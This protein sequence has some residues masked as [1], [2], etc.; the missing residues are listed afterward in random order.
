MEPYDPAGIP[1]GWD[2]AQCTSDHPSLSGGTNTGFA[3]GWYGEDGS[4]SGACWLGN[5]Q[6]IDG[7]IHYPQLQTYEFAWEL[8]VNIPEDCAAC[9]H[10]QAEFTGDDAV[11]FSVN[12]QSAGGKYPAY[13]SLFQFPPNYGGFVAGNNVL[14]LNITNYDG[15]YGAWGALVKGS[16]S[17][18]CENIAQ[19][20]DVSYLECTDS[21]PPLQQMN[22]NQ[23]T[24]IK[25]LNLLTG[26]YMPKYSFPWAQSGYTIYNVNA[27][28]ASPRD[29]IMYAMIRYTEGS[30]D[31]FL[32]RIGAEDPVKIRFVARMGPSNAASFDQHGNLFYPSGWKL[33]KLSRPDLIM[34]EH[35]LP[36]NVPA[37]DPKDGTEEV[38]H[39]YIP[40]WVTGFPA[41][42]GAVHADLLQSGTKQEWLIGLGTLEAKL[43]LIRTDQP[44][45][46]LNNQ[47]NPDFYTVDADGYVTD[48][49]G[50]AF[51]YRD[52]NGDHH[53][54]FL[55]NSGGQKIF[56][57]DLATVTLSGSGIAGTGT[58]TL[59]R[60]G[61][62]NAV[63]AS[64]DG[65][66]C[67]LPLGGEVPIIPF[68]TCNDQDGVNVGLD[69]N[70]ITDT[71]C[72]PGV[73]ANPDSSYR[74][75]PPAFSYASG[76]SCI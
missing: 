58:A 75:V 9:A 8:N 25:E 33:W 24:S 47:I 48:T 16:I 22:G 15:N 55:G 52:H 18:D 6:R 17:F 5:N 53:I 1:A 31:S 56:E 12:G 21:N 19:I 66:T 71:Q 45:W 74:S 34:N 65:I 61:V 14:Q 39:V 29:F 76:D 30:P 73:I 3:G 28:D 60:L 57:L 2:F 42:L 20:S 46:S 32:A 23:Q 7:S 64:N 13:S 43:F 37:N 68:P 10:F 36:Q 40:G 63:S 49:Y 4:L 67:K 38:A 59:K 51:T 44:S 62:G 54:Y 11:T 50:A 35:V 26:T 27:A 72:G 70:P 41:D 69:P